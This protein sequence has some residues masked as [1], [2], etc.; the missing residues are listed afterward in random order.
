[1]QIGNFGS[2]YKQQAF[3]RAK[4]TDKAPEPEKNPQGIKQL[5]EKPVSH[6]PPT[7]DENINNK[8]FNTFG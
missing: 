3:A 5:T 7:V 4:Q 1:M 6:K 8:G 2:Y